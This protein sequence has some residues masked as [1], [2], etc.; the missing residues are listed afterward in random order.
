MPNTPR[1]SRTLSLG[2]LD[3]RNTARWTDIA[4]DAFLATWPPRETDAPAVPDQQVREDAPVLA[5]DEALEVALDLDGVLLAREAEALRE[6]ADMSVDDHALRLA[7]LR[8]D[9]VRGLPR[10]SR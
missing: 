2:A 7:Q 6:A 3:R 8:G 4:E 1:Q 10:N 5:R 9:D